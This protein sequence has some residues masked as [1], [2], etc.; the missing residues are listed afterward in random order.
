MVCG[1]SFQALKEV[2]L[3]KS[4]SPRLREAALEVLTEYKKF[5]VVSVFLEI[6]KNDTSTRLQSS[7]VDYLTEHI[8]DKNR[9]V[10]TLIELYH[11]IPKNRREQRESIFYSIAE[12]GNEKAI[13]FLATV[14]K[15]DN[16]YDM[17][18]EAIYYLGSI[19]N[20]KART[21]LYDILKG[22]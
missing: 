17:R 15:S 12:V 9:S 16:D 14:A 10:E 5:D 13:D 11:A 8:K 7:A 6:A 3:D 1:K 19:G 20:E 21:V 4:Q 2:A 18:R 22:K